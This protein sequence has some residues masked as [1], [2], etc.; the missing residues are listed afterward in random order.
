MADTLNWY[1]KLPAEVWENVPFKKEKVPRAS[2]P[3]A[4]DLWSIYLEREKEILATWRSQ[5]TR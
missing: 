5:Q 4:A 1:K 3:A 2:I